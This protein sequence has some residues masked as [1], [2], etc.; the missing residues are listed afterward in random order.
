MLHFCFEKK[1]VLVVVTL[2]TASGVLAVALT[3]AASDQVRPLLQ[4]L[5]IISCTSTGPCQEGKN[6]GTGPG[7]EGIS[8]KGKGIIGQTTF[9]STSSSNGQAGMLGQDMSTS[10]IFNVGVSGTSTNGIGVSGTSIL[11]NQGQGTG[12]YGRG[13]RDFYADSRT[14]GEF[15]FWGFNSNSSKRFSVDGLANTVI[16]GG[17]VV[18]GEIMAGSGFT[19]AC[20][21]CASGIGALVQSNG[22]RPALQ[23]Y[24]TSTST[25]VADFAGG[26]YPRLISAENSA[27]ST[28]FILDDS[29]N[30][31]ISGKIFTQGSCH[32]GCASAHKP[33]KH[34]T[35]YAP[36]ESQ[37][38][39][40]DFGEAQLIGGRA[41]VSL[42][43]AYA[44]VINGHA[45][46]MVFITP[47]GESR[48]LYVTQRSDAGFAVREN[49]GGRST[50]AFTY[51]IVAKPYADNSPRLPVTISEPSHMSLP[52]APPRPT[53]PTH[54]PNI[55]GLNGQPSQ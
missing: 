11:N 10:G 35:T 23:V 37:P 33:G 42:D 18:A 16:D 2:L 19:S 25:Q 30:I 38:T 3:P 28:V 53:F 55:A 1:L 46:Y 27:L 6:S 49:Q 32:D 17:L 15:M 26:G 47:E 41:Y 20:S 36:Q 13:A 4:S 54:L 43:P 50:L 40:E 45:T 24:A 39:M 5:G 8:A 22:I 9:K 21:S 51:R 44:S 29:G 31:V 48:G 14:Q 7:L 52:H 34:V 12:V